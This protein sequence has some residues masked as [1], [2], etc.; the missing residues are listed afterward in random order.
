MLKWMI[1]MLWRTRGNYQTIVSFHKLNRKTQ[2]SVKYVPQI[3]ANV[4]NTKNDAESSANKDNESDNMDHPSKNRVDNVP[5]GELKNNIILKELSSDQ[6]KVEAN[7]D[8][9]EDSVDTF[10]REDHE[11]VVAETLPLLEAELVTNE[12]DVSK[13]REQPMTPDVIAKD[14]NIIKNAMIKSPTLARD[15]LG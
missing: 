13:G 6:E 3:E 9:D 1:K 7:R 5:K 11:E 14:L 12:N 8:D 4:S 15:I 10:F 2:A